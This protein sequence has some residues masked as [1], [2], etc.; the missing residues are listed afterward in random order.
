[1]L[2]LPTEQLCPSSS[3]TICHTVT[4]HTTKPVQGVGF[5]RCPDSRTHRSLEQVM[6]HVNDQF[7]HA[8]VSELSRHPV[9]ASASTHSRV[10]P[11]LQPPRGQVVS[12]LSI[13]TASSSTPFKHSIPI[14]TRTHIKSDYRSEPL[15]IKMCFD[16]SAGPFSWLRITAPVDACAHL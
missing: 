5:V 7:I 11:H 4:G 15:S 1:M 14:R 12:C 3:V 9:S 16:A 13:F 2:Q 6:N 8:P 10:Q